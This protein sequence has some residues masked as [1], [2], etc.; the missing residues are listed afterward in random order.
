MIMSRFKKIILGLL[1]V[2]IAIQFVRPARNRNDQKQ[3]A[4]LATIFTV[5]DSE[6]G[7][8]QNGCY[9]CHS[10]NTNYPWYANIQPLAW[11]MARHI[12][13]GK[14]QLNFSEFGIISKRKQISRLREMINQV[15]DDEMPLA[16]YQLMNS[17]AKLS[18]S[19]KA[20]LLKWLTSAA[21]SLQNQ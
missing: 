9:D 21:D 18:A 2:L 4:D 11:I 16:S 17:N 6:Q 5:P 12:T 8:L 1:I 14:A 20:L 3:P 13:K 7:I 10:N 19:E 15:K